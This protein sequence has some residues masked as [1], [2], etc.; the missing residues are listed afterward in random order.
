MQDIYW[1]NVCKGKRER[2][3]KRQ[4]ELLDSDAG[5]IPVNEDGKDREK[6]ERLD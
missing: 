5:V 6:E 1:G 4:G 3:Q 2:I